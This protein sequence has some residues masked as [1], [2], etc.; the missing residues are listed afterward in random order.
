MPRIRSRKFIVVFAVICAFSF[1]AD[2]V[3]K[4][5]YV[6]PILMYHS[7]KPAVA[8]GDRLTVSLGTFERQMRFLKEHRYRV[9]GL[10][11]LA[12]MIR[13][14]RAIP[15][16]TV[17]LT[18]DDGYRDNFEIAF[19]VLKKYGFPATVFLIG[20]EIGT[21][22]WMGW[23]EIRAMQ[24]TG[25]IHFGSHTMTHPCLV[26]TDKD[27]DCVREVR[28]SKRLL[29]EGLGRSVT[30]FSYPSGRFNERVRRE[31]IDA[32]YAAAVV[33]N[34]GKRFPNNDVYALKRL[35]ISENAS[36]LFVFAVEISGFYNF[37]REQRR[38]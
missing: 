12:E 6:V 8:P 38:K 7:V 28:E 1:G 17:A 4:R 16:K 26:D 35:R 29:E 9:I 34:P 14:R 3:L 5:I 37:M 2:Y 22:G 10:P 30:I 24:A 21:S 33:T 11:E 25:L 19:P 31:V 32:G 27:I 20:K 15:Y 23:E 36:N 13:N 18:F